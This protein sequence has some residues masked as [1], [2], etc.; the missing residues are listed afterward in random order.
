MGSVAERGTDDHCCGVFFLKWVLY[1]FNCILLLSGAGI[2]AVGLW[3]FFDKQWLVGILSSRQEFVDVFLVLMYSLIG[4]G[5]FV[6]LVT[7]TVGCCAT[8]SRSRTCLMLYSVLLMV[9]FILEAGSGV[10]TYLYEIKVHENVKYLVNVTLVE[11]Y[12]VDSAARTAIDRM[13]E[14]KR[15]CGSSSHNDWLASGWVKT[16]ANHSSIAVPDS[17]C[18]TPSEG[19]GSRVNPNNIFMESCWPHMEDEFRVHLN[20]MSAVGLG[21]CCLQI[22]GM[23]FACCLAKRARK[24]KSRNENHYWHQ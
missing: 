13:Q 3:T 6:I 20:I 23:V 16:A 24:W 17:C 19:C 22:F 12:H 15:C 7:F 10:L 2:L 8:V 9:V 1:I 5:G 14:S 21:L 4:I 11:R 18:K